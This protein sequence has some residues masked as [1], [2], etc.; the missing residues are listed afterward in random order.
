MT[1]HINST[2]RASFNG[3][4]PFELALLLLDSKLLE[5]LQLHI[6]ESDKIILTP[7][8]LKH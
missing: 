7:K 3:R 4:T 5:L 2:A 1:N 6:I 8:L